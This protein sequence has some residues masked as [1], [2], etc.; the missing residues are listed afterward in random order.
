MVPAQQTSCLSLLKRLGDRGCI[1]FD[2]DK[3]DRGEFMTI[4][5]SQPGHDRPVKNANE[6]REF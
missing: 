4:V 2:C 6:V 5:Y 3:L 1:K